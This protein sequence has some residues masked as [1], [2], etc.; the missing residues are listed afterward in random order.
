ML[1]LGSVRTEELSMLEILRATYAFPRHIED[2]HSAVNVE[3]GG[4]P[5]GVN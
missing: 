2:P 4:L 1:E 5:Y 3:P